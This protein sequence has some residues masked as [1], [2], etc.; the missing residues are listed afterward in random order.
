MKLNNHNVKYYA[1]TAYIFFSIAWGLGYPNYFRF[2]IY[3]IFCPIFVLI[4][5]FNNKIY[6]I[7]AGTIIF[8][9]S[10]LF[11]TYLIERKHESIYYVSFLL[12]YFSLVSANLKSVIFN[13]NLF[14]TF[15]NVIKKVLFVALIANFYQIYFNNDL[16]I[17][18][19]FPEPSH[20]GFSLGPLIG[21]LLFVRPTRYI[22]I[23]YLIAFLTFSPSST[24][25]LSLVIFIVFWRLRE[26]SKYKLLSLTIFSLAIGV[27][28]L[29]FMGIYF[30]EFA[31]K[32]NASQFAWLYGFVRAFEFFPSAS[33]FGV[34]PF[35]WIP[36]TGE[37]DASSLALELL[38]QRDLASLI[39]FGLAS[40]G[41]VFIPF[42]FFGIFYLICF[43]KKSIEDASLSIILLTYLITFCFRWAGP[44][45][46]PFLPLVGLLVS[47]RAS[48]K[49]KKRK[50][51]LN[52]RR[53]QKNDKIND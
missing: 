12:I 24:L 6:K 50:I 33:V 18:G 19:I 28:V 42:L 48:E 29:I 35:G 17:S 3:I 13:I 25:V 27:F 22:A 31:E 40:Y 39:P 11:F 20:L 30:P 36:I 1:L 7:P 52:N 41:I 5:I 10:L 38:N 4:S 47:Y 32:K 53:F 46:N 16:F 51:I 49:I 9:L 37:E 45:L 43:D 8:S 26:Y 14:D 2:P 34:G 15:L 44:T 23:F 21:I